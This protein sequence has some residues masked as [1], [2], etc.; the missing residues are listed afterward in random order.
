MFKV[1]LLSVL[2]ASSA[3]HA[4]QDRTTFDREAIKREQRIKELSAA[5]PSAL[6][7]CRRC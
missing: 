5:P 6:N 7:I 2:L 4:A 1:T 3:V